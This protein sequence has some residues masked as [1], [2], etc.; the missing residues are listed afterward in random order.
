MIEGNKERAGLQMELLCFLSGAQSSAQDFRL[1]PCGERAG[2]SE[3]GVPGA[4]GRPGGGQ[5]VASGG[6]GGNSDVLNLII[7]R[8]CLSSDQWVPTE[9]K[10]PQAAA[11]V[12]ASGGAESW[13][14]ERG[15]T[16]RARSRTSRCR[17]A[18][19]REH[20]DGEDL[21]SYAT[22]LPPSAPPP[23]QGPGSSWGRRGGGGGW[24]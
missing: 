5:R 8:R 17:S 10:A 20:T 9:D 18:S 3:E 19:I 4:T 21:R 14:A 1:H 7:G 23:R 6:R 15:Q 22:C 11:A 24:R 2:G 12:S 16:S 13:G